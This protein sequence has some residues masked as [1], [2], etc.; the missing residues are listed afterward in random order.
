MSAQQFYS[1]QP[2][3]DQ[4]QY[5]QQ[6]PPQAWG[7]H[8]VNSNGYEQYPPPQGGGYQPPS[9]APPPPQMTSSEPYAEPQHYAPPKHDPSG[10]A[11]PQMADARFTT[12]KR[13]ND[14]IPLILFVGVFCGMIVVAG[15]SIRQ[16]VKYNGGGGGFGKSWQGGTGVTTSLN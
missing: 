14:I 13:V 10:M 6:P 8:N 9:H 3:P 1:G 11:A 12:K 16:F 15:I 5:Q 2:G 4:Y 7:N